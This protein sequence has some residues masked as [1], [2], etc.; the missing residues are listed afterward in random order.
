MK[1]VRIRSHSPFWVRDNQIFVDSI[2]KLTKVLTMP[3]MT[4]NYPQ[5]MAIWLSAAF[6][7]NNKSVPLSYSCSPN[8]AV[9]YLYKFKSNFLS[10]R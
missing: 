9:V 2:H 4:F 8:S 3:A 10:T 1:T 5:L 7:K 6:D